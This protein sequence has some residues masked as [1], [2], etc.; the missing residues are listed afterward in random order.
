MRNVAHTQAV[1]ALIG[2]ELIIVLA[3]AIIVFAMGM[4]PIIADE[5]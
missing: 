1:A 2:A 3:I 4:E 5:E